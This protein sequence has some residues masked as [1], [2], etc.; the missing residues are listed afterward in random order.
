MDYQTIDDC[1]NILQTFKTTHPCLTKMWID[2]FTKMN[3]KP[4]EN[5]IKNCLIAIENMKVYPDISDEQA[6]II[7]GVGTMLQ[8]FPNKILQ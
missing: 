5:E 4:N 7:Y 3:D 6:S 1:L 2:Y 8:R